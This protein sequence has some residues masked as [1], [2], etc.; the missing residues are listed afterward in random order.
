MVVGYILHGKL[1][2]VLLRENGHTLRL[3]LEHWN[4][5]ALSFI[6]LSV[7]ECLLIFLTRRKA[8][9]SQIVREDGTRAVRECPS[10]LI[11]ARGIAR[12]E[13]LPRL[14]LLQHCLSLRPDRVGALFASVDWR[15]QSILSES[16]LLLQDLQLFTT[17]CP[18]TMVV[19][20]AKSRLC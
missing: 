10:V 11:A 20:T 2:E 19:H 4:L 14:C 16:C 18:R 17:E 9:K 7:C 15:L 5:A 1:L 3:G 13:R 12:V 6:S 8:I